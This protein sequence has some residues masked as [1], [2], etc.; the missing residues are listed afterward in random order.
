MGSE[1]RQ[2]WK[3]EKK[4]CEKKLSGSCFLAPTCEIVVQTQSWST[5]LIVTVGLVTTGITNTS[6]V[7]TVMNENNI[8]RITVLN[9]AIKSF[10]NIFLGWQVMASVVHQNNH[11]LFFESLT[12]H[13]M[14]LDILD[15]IVATT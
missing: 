6:S 9:N 7:T 2:D 10:Q 13:Q 4:K 3:K 11:I 5:Y 8:A 1:S 14:F 15:I 12:L